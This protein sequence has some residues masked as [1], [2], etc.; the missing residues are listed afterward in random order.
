MKNSYARTTLSHALAA[1]L[2]GMAAGSAWA[3]APTAPQAAPTAPQAAPAPAPAGDDA[4]KQLDTVNVSGY[5]RSIQFSTDAK[6]DSVTFSD[7]VFAEDIGKFP[8]MNIAESL[9]RI[10]GVQ[11]ARD[12]NGEGLNIAIRGLGTSFTKTTLNGASIATASIGINAQNQNREVDLNLFPT[13]F[14]TQLTVSKTPTASMLEGGV[15][16]VV[17]MRS[18]RPFDRPGTHLTY[19]LQGDWNST[20]E[21]T[22]P[23]GALMGSW[24]NEAGTFGALFGVASV[25]SKLG[26]EGFETI[27]WTNPGLTYAQCGLTPPA[28]TPSSNQ[29]AA[30]NATGG[31]NWRIPDTVP[32]TAG[33]GLTPGQS[34]DAAWLLAHNPGLSIAQ[35]SDALIPRL[36]RRVQMQGDRDRDASVMSLEWRPSDTAHF[37]LDTLFSKAKRTT[38]RTSMNLI[39][40][41]GNML[42]LDMQLD[43]NN[44]VTDATLTNAQ[45]FLEA[46]PYR[47]QVKFWS[48]NPGAELLFGADQDIK[49]N[50]QANATRSWL[51]RQSPSVLVTSPFTTVDYRNSGGDQPSITSPLDLDDPN[52]GWSWTGGRLNISN[53]KR[54]TETRGARAELQFGEDKRNIK[55]GV[56]YDQAERRI[57]GF[58]NS[59]AWETQV[60]RG[61]ATTCTGGAGSLIPQ[62]ALASYLKPGPGGFITVDFDRFLRDSGYYGLSASAPETNAANTG[63]STGGIL[64]KNWGFYV[65]TNAETDVWNRSLRFNAGVRYVTTDQTISGPVT[66][67]GV[68]RYQVLNSSYNELLPSFNLAWDVADSV[69]L[70]LSGSRTLTR[71]DPSAMLPNTNFSDPSAQTATQGNSNLAPYRSTNVDIGGEWY[72]GGEGFV[73]LTLFDKRIDGFTVNGVRRI[74]FLD[75]GVDYSNLSATQQAALDQRG[76][77]NAATVDVQTQVNAD[78]TLN[79]R[80][81]EAIWVQPLDRL[82][83]GLG[84]S[85]NYTH[86]KQASEG[87]G[88]QAVAVGVAPNLWNGTVYWEKNNASVRLSYA[89]N[90]D[91]I[92]SG[93]NQNGIPDARLMAD[94]RGQLDLS[95]SY[96]LAWIRSAPQITLNV[97]NLTDEPLRTTFQYPNATYDL[98]RPGRTIMLGIR[99]SF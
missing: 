52:L 23:R 47:E 79:I 78:G 20:S 2:L 36:G 3:Q 93:A 59:T 54:E 70:R 49:L 35:I 53:E 69:V 90:D 56:A 39:G 37:Y 6:R 88:I 51:Y 72:T 15:S 60:C 91:M 30:C 94:A 77:P 32:V 1:A 13:E 31:G 8:D 12:V 98:Y 9:N 42:P 21:K 75:L 19:Q 18:A 71:P 29:P 17:D 97:T 63:A 41:N 83:D 10:P 64:E 99:G 45:Y 14:F 57:R 61:A 84:F 4:V 25:R 28:G 86:V 33:A 82:F 76:G 67:G 89:W 27:G 68:R 11:L 65:E 81:L 22:T 74:P 73:G 5:R 7:T 50:V 34:I 26:V 55:V 96:T 48:V 16:G 62:S 66:I 87:D 85:L 80:G 24:T 44:V 92:I 46:R 58:D 95:A 43:D 38:E 40:R